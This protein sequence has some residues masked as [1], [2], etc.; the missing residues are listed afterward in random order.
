MLKLESEQP[1]LDGFDKA[2]AAVVHLS[3]FSQSLS[4]QLLILIGPSNNIHSAGTRTVQLK[5]I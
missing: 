4:Q 1:V 5:C 3:D 2:T